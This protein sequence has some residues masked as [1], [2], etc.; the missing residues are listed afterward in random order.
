MTDANTLRTLQRV[1]VV[2][3]GRLRSKGQLISEGTP[4]GIE[5]IDGLRAAGLGEGTGGTGRAA[6]PPSQSGGIVPR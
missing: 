4:C 5:V 3:L 6:R 1:I 2:A